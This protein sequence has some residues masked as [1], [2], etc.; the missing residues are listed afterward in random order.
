[1]KSITFKDLLGV[2]SF[3]NFQIRSAELQGYPKMIQILAK[4]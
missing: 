2:I 1:M 4:L 3:Y